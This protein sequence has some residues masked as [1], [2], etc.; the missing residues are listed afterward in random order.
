M[1]YVKIHETEG[2]RIVAACDETLLGK[3]F[4]EGTRV[5]DLKAYQPFYK[6]ERIK[7]PELRSALRNF[8]SANLVGKQAIQVAIEAG[9][10]TESNVLHVSNVPYL[11]IY[12]I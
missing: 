12:K 5:L 9:L 1:M 6:G 10:A 11:H 2:N 4:R 8:S 3:V 7:A